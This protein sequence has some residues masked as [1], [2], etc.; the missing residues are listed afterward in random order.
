[1][2]IVTGGAGFIGSAMVW[3]LN[4]MGVSDILIVDNLGTGEKWKNMV[5]LRFADYMHRDAFLR[6]VRDGSLP[7]PVQAVVHMGACSATTERDAEFLMAN[8]YIYSRTIAEFC[9]ERGI[10]MLNASSAATYGDGAQGFSDDENG[11]DALRPLNMYGYTKQ[12]FD[13]WAQR[14]GSLSRLASLK[15][16]NVFGPNEYHK[17]DMRS[18]ACKATAAI[19]AEGGMR[20]FAS[21]HPDF[22]DGGQRRDFVYVKDCVEVMAWLLEHPG[23]N[24]VF[25]VGTGRSRSFNALV[26]AVF[27]AMG[28][29]EQI[30]YVPMPE[31]LQGKYQ[32]YTQAEMSKLAAAGCPVRFRSLEES[33]AEYVQQYLT[34]DDPYLGNKEDEHA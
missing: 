17:G 30:D 32:S 4:H 2:Y 15:F 24:G 27:A 19:Q 34:R 28:R 31:A 5:N 8:N 10:R 22:P 20:L 11:L 23:V 13:L 14:S 33:V 25:N 1:M 9:L 18:V 3:K 16:F 26:R 21:D 7:G 6:L 29:A 12:L